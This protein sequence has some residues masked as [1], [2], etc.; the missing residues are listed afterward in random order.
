M[1]FF[2]FV[3]ITKPACSCNFYF[4]REDGHVCK[5]TFTFF[6]PFPVLC[7]IICDV[8]DMGFP[9]PCIICAAQVPY[10]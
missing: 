7:I 10:F 2:D 6:N 3:S 1:N 4:H 9:R 5:I 8:H